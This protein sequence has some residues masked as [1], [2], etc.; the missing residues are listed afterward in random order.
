[1]SDVVEYRIRVEKEYR[2][3]ERL[4]RHLQSLDYVPRYC[5]ELNLEDGDPFTRI[6]GQII[7][8]SAESDLLKGKSPEAIAGAAIYIA[9]LL[10]EKKPNQSDIARVAGI[11]EVTL[12]ARIRDMM[13]P[14]EEVMGHK[15]LQRRKYLLGR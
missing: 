13:A 15:I 12:R 9:G 8:G 5:A 10:L 11:T 6:A 14:L 2:K 4:R 3:H 1:M 7:L